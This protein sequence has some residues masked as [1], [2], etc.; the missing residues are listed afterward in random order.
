MSRKRYISTEISVD[1]VVNRLAVKH[2]DFAALLYTWM[3][4]HAKDNGTITGDIESLL[5][6]VIPGRRDKNEDDVRVAIE[7]MAELGLVTLDKDKKVIQFPQSFFKYQKYVTPARI[8][9]CEEHS[10]KV[11]SLAESCEESQDSQKVASNHEE[12]QDS[13]TL[14]ENHAHA[15]RAPANRAR[16]LSLSSFKSKDI[17]IGERESACADAGNSAK[18]PEE[19]SL[20]KDIDEL[21]QFLIEL[22]KRPEYAPGFITRTPQDTALRLWDYYQSRGWIAGTAAMKDWKAVMRNC[23]R[24]NVDDIGKRGTHSN[25]SSNGTGGTGSNF[26]GNGHIERPHYDDESYDPEQIYAQEPPAGHR[27]RTAWENAVWQREFGRR[28]REGAGAV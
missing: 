20:P 25:G 14:A 26:S 17:V 4:P 10:Q 3:I 13:Q 19:N 18:P 27:Y 28:N 6:M 24:R 9:Q 5:M 23:I 21:T 7:A 15:N 1:K 12:S 22:S 8:A 2:G 11:A 16:S